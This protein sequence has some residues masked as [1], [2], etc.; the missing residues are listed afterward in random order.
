MKNSLL[1]SLYQHNTA[2]THF[3]RF[4]QQSKAEAT[5]FFVRVESHQDVSALASL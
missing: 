4:Q 1:Y 2:S 5:Q 3:H